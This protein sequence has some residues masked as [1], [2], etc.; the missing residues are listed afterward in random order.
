VGKQLFTIGSVKKRANL[1][2]ISAEGRKQINVSK[3]SALFGM[4]E[5]GQRSGN[6]AILASKILFSFVLSWG[7]S[8]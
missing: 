1:N 5:D 8:L 7:Q 6:P 4:L 2:V 3:R